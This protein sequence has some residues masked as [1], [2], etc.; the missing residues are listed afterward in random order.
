MVLLNACLNEELNV[1]NAIGIMFFFVPCMT[2]VNTIND[3]LRSMLYG[4]R[5]MG[6]C[7]DVAISEAAHAWAI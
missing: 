3:L 1:L 4:L 6:M 7:H 2:G 5:P